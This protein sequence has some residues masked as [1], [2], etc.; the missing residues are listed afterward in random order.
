MKKLTTLFA[1]AMLIVSC[2]KNES[3]SA[4]QY[5]ECSVLFECKTQTSIDEITK[6]T[7]DLPTELIPD[8]GLF[9]L[10]MTGEYVDYDTE[11]TKS[12][13][14]YYAT[15]NDYLDN[16]PL[17]SAGDYSASISYGDISVEG[18]NNPCFKGSLD[19]EII[20]RKTSEETISAS[21]SNSAI[22]VVTTDWFNYYYSDAEFI[23]TTSLGNEFSF[24]ADDDQL[25]FVEALTELTLK[26]SAK[27]A[28]TGTWTDFSESVIGTTA[29]CTVYTITIDASQAGGAQITIYFNQEFTNVAVDGG[30]LNPEL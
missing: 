14:S 1:L 5:G 27:N 13:S 7:Y 22:R 2:N 18:A 24:S 8:G 30:E 23:V 19:F 6:A 9:S 3:S 17:L 25:I 16:V 4:E 20:A 29:A 11:E 15:L 12:Y 26:G 21:L 28:Q 10:T